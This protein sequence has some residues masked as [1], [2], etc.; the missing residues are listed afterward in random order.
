MFSLVRF[1]AFSL[2]ALGLVSGSALSA[3]DFPAKPI[4]II[5]P[6]PAGTTGDL[7]VREIA[8]FVSERLKQT[9]IVDNR[10]GAGGSIGSEMAAHSRPDGLTVLFMVSSTLTI[11]PHL[12]KTPT[13]DPVKDLRPFIVTVRSGAIVVVNTSSSIQSLKDLIAAA[14]VK[15]GGLTYA[16]SGPGSVQHVMGERLKKMAEIDL[17]HVPYKGDALALTDLIGGQ[18]DV[19]FGFAFATLPHI[20]SGKLRPLAVTR[21]KRL[22]ALPDIP[23][24][25][26]SGVRGYEEHVWAGFAVP[27]AT[28][29]PI[30]DKLFQAFHSA[31]SLS[32]Y[33]QLAEKRGS[34]S[35]AST[36]E[37]AV[38]LLKRDYERNRRVVKEL[39]LQVE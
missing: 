34:E 5:V 14:K 1:L 19:A 24:I 23:T 21:A 36:Q 13:F 3:D 18:V 25:A 7:N 20:R 9:I 12:Q 17:L 15:P 22:S 30:V 2:L 8:P 39:G 26:E 33:R 4:R 16:T 29:K 38:E 35:L 31:A 10:P 37:E 11:N 32:E 28:P 6:F 27:A